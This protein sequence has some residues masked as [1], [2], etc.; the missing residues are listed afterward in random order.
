MV[1]SGPIGKYVQKKAAEIKRVTMYHDPAKVSQHFEDKAA[2]HRNHIRPCSVPDAQNE[3]Y[4]NDE[5][6]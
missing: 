5:T 6:E 1:R 4:A 2:Q 3:L